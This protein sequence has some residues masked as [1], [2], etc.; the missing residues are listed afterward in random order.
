MAS[1][2]KGIADIFAEESENDQTFYGFSDTDVGDFCDLK[3][4]R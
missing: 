3:V 2:S 1:L 4:S